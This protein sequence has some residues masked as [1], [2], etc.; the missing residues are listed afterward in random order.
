MHDSFISTHDLILPRNTIVITVVIVIH[1]DLYVYNYSREMNPQ[2]LKLKP[3]LK[4]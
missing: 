2:G 1:S 3:K 4:L